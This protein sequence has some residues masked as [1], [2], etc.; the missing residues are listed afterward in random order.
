M[1]RSVSAAEANRQ[2]S[3]LLAEVRKG[4]IYIITSH[5]KAVARIGPVETENTLARATKSALLDRLRDQPLT[6]PV[7]RWTRSE[8]YEG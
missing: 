3:H 2:F 8:L 7:G 6:N 5:G 1:A 4:R